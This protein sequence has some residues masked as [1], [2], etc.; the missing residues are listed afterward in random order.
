[1]EGHFEC[2]LN[3]AAAVV[4]N[5]TEGK[6][7]VNNRIFEHIY[8]PREP[9]PYKGCDVGQLTRKYDWTPGGARPATHEPSSE[10]WLLPRSRNAFFKKTILAMQ[11]PEDA[12]RDRGGAA[13]AV[14]R[15]WIPF[16]AT[17][18]ERGMARHANKAS[19]CCPT[20]K[21]IGRPQLL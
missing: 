18:G 15:L 1:M 17:E 5:T 13:E 6:T 21:A 8:A 2:T 16:S 19:R 3:S 11:G 7:L 9:I 10:H 4:E 20:D 12:D 14:R